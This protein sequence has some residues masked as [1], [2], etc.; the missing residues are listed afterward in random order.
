MPHIMMKSQTSWSVLEVLEEVGD[1]VRVVA[2][3]EHRRLDDVGVGWRDRVEVDVAPGDVEHLGEA[4]AHTLVRAVEGNHVFLA[5][6]GA[7]LGGRQVG[8][9]AG[10]GVF[11]LSRELGHG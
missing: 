11:D 7:M 2:L 4:P 5:G 6:H 8:L 9:L 3:D 10:E 1:V